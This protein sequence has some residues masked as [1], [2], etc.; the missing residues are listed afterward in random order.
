MG[1]EADACN[2]PRSGRSRCTRLATCVGTRRLGGTQNRA[3][4][5]HQVGHLRRHE[6]VRLL[7][8]LQQM[9]FHHG[10][11]FRQAMGLSAC[12]F[13]NTKGKR[14]AMLPVQREACQ[15]SH[16]RNNPQQSAVHQ[17]MES[18]QEGGSSCNPSRRQ[19]PLNQLKS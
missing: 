4:E 11:G 14:P 6:A 16:R 12:R 3:L 8:P 13:Q 5:M 9:L 17:P 15:H 7:G 19:G 1:E 10:S 2:A 18:P